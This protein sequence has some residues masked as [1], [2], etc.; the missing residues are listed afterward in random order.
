M[1]DSNVKESKNGLHSSKCTPSNLQFLNLTSRKAVFFTCAILKSQSVK[2]QSSK[3]TSIKSA[4][5]KLQFEKLQFSYS[6]PDTGFC[7]KSVLL[8]FSAVK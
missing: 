6:F 8:K 5:E 1:H 3:I 7:E 2:Q 4:P